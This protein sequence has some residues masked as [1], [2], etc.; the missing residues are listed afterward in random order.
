[1]EALSVV[2]M[3][4]E[5]EDF[6]AVHEHMEK[7]E[8]AFNLKATIDASLAFMGERDGAG[9]LVGANYPVEYFTERMGLSR[10]EAFARLQRGQALF[11]EA[12]AP[13]PEPNLEPE[14][15]EKQKE[16]ERKRAE[17]EKKA[18]E[19]A[20]REAAEN[21]IS[22]EKHRIIER[23]LL[24]LNEHSDPGRNEIYA[25]ALEAAK[26][27]NSA[28]L[29]KYVE[30]IVRRANRKGKDYAGKKDPL[31][32]HKK[33]SFHM[34]EPDA[35][36]VV[37]ISG[38]LA[39]AEAAALKAALA[40]GLAPGSNTS[41]DSSDDK[42]TRGQRLA[43]QLNAIVNSYSQ[44]I[45]A[46]NRGIGSVVIAMTMDDLAGADWETR[47]CTNTGIDLNSFDILRLGM[48]GS[49]FVLQLDSVTGIPL[50]M[51]RTRLANLMLKIVMFVMQA[52]CARNGCTKPVT[53]LE[54]HHILAYLQGGLTD[55]ENLVLLCREHHRC[56]ND[57]RDGADNMG[58]ID[59]DLAT[60]ETGFM[61]ADGSPMQ[62]N[63]THQHEQ[64][65]GQKLRRRARERYP[66]FDAENRPA[67]DP[68][69]Y[70]PPNESGAW[71]TA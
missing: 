64:A 25:Q 12:Q 34:S 11:G 37:T 2:M 48:A 33:R 52:V 39:A 47:F 63:T 68:L 42:R 46:K 14:D 40:P 6:F 30:D 1:M 24:N 21:K 69:L 8:E 45:V 56:N 59:R 9:R 58:Y 18:Q 31:A 50:S 3:V 44:D 32:G 70:P 20:R 61:P 13:K 36:G 17:R 51:G 5:N 54:A 28:D 23:A 19:K 29:R 71:K 41:K 26:T 35:D 16:E 67:Q 15:E 4:P 43:D 7:L 55:I 60:W 49:D 27:R 62:P 53:E 66:D 22:A 10:A 38:K 57:Q 65:P